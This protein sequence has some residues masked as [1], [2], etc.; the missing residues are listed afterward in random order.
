MIRMMFLV[1][2]A[3]A[4]PI[5]FSGQLAPP[6][7]ELLSDSTEFISWEDLKPGQKGYG[8]TVFQGDKPERFE[9]EFAGVTDLTSKVKLV[10][11]RMGHPLEN[12][13]VLAGMSGSPVYFEQ[14]GKWKL[15]GALAYSIGSFSSDKFLGGITPIQAMLNQ[16][17]F[18]GLIQ[19]NSNVYPLQ[20]KIKNLAN[21]TV[22]T[23]NL[24]SAK[25][26]RPKP[27]EAITI[28]LAEGDF[29]DYVLGTITFVKGN[30]FYALGH[31]FLGA[32]K[33]ILPAYKSAV[34]TSFKSHGKGFKIEDREESYIGYISYDNS[35]G[36]EGEIQTFP[37]N[38][39]LPINIEV[40]IE[41]NGNHKKASFSFS[42]F[43]DKISTQE[44]IGMATEE[45][46]GRLWNIK[47]KATIISNYTIGFEDHDPIEFSDTY[48]S[49][50]ITE[51]GPFLIIPS[52]WRVVYRAAD[53]VS[54]LLRSDWDF[55]IK[56]VQIGINLQPGDQM[57][58]LDAFKVI[59]DK[60]RPVAK[61]KL[62]QTVNLA[63]GLRKVD[64][65]NQFIAYIPLQIPKKLD[66]DDSDS[67][68]DAKEIN[69]YIESGNN[70][71]ERDENKM[72][73]H[74][75]DNQEEFLREFLINERSPQK[76]YI[77]IVFP[78]TQTDQKNPPPLTVPDASWQRVP[79]LNA[80]R[81]AKSFERKVVLKE[82]DSPLKGY[83]INIHTEFQLRITK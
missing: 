34:A 60:G 70:F 16:E 2:T 6:S 3:T 33:I 47:N 19:T 4:S 38:A 57:L 44:I 21:S 28:F 83:I 29:S 46:L 50:Q 42:A 63:L 81:S 51:F 30:K 15:A 69:I 22:G 71:I 26:I 54:R 25:P 61:V 20:P 39:M 62:G 12:S 59:D 56:N 17:N 58:V 49:G 35:F 52:P 45:L 8:L 5:N 41:E 27:G 53:D 72:L 7:I 74:R 23:K 31:P 24:R 37:E 36:V 65:A 40:A 11:V 68:K 79:N 1:L 10:L 76:I 73:S 9:V 77:Q 32:G 80:L 18:S 78:E 43:K 75:P 67:D 48:S 55:K 82:L 13:E 64:G 14:Q 66:L